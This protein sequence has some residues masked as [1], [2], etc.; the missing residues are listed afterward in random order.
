MQSPKLSTENCLSK[1]SKQLIIIIASQN[2]INSSEGE[3]C[4]FFLIVD[5]AITANKGV[6]TP[7][8]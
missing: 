6:K 7:M 2:F 3:L 1:S 4:C 8:I 5:V